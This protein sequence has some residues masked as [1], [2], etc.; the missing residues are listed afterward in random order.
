[1]VQPYQFEQAITADES[2]GIDELASPLLPNLI[3]CVLGANAGDQFVGYGLS[4]TK[5]RSGSEG[6][7]SNNYRITLTTPSGLLQDIAEAA[8]AVFVGDATADA[9]LIRQMFTRAGQSIA[10]THIKAAAVERDQQADVQFFQVKDLGAMTA[11]G[12]RDHQLQ[13]YE[14]LRH[15]IGAWA[16]P[17][18]GVA[19]PLVGF[20]DHKDSARPGDGKWR[21]GSARGGNQFQHHD[22][23]VLVGSPLKNISAALAEYLALTGDVS[24]ATGCS[25][26][27]NS[28]GFL[29]FQARD[30]GAEVSQA[31]NRMRMI[32]RPGKKLL[33]LFIS[34]LDT[35]SLGI[36][37]QQVKAADITPKAAHKTEKKLAAI[38]DAICEL[39]DEGTPIEKI[40]TR[41]AAKVAGVGETS[42]RRIAQQQ[43]DGRPWPA[44]VAEILGAD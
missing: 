6:A 29:C 25:P 12:R 40:S 3:H 27:E 17:L 38:V 32:R 16:S 7:K 21:T 44:F 28:P 30:T 13:R 36:D 34:E 15:G 18:I 23:L 43:T 22:V 14:A 5:A 2:G 31:W 20:I 26:E 37:V 33:I 10:F 42:V 19:N 41:K 11:R 8:D 9:D 1:M 24:A 39:A 35:S 4:V